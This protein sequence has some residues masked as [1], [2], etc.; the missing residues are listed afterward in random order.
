MWQLSTP[1][2][3]LKIRKRLVVPNRKQLDRVVD[4]DIH[5]NPVARQQVLHWPCEV[6]RLV[7]KCCRINRLAKPRRS[8]LM[9]QV[10]VTQI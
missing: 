7:G 6:D 1:E 10:K 3:L 8:Y 4:V 2:R 5:T 9:I